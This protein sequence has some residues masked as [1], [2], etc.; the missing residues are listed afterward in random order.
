MA[1]ECIPLYTPGDVVTAQTTAAVTGKRVVA[2]T[3]AMA[4]GLPKVAHAT[5]AGAKFGIAVRDAASGG[6]VP[7][8]RGKGVILPVTAGAGIS[9]LAE[10]EVGTA[11]KVVTK[12]SGIAIGRALD[13]ASADGSDVFIELY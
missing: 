5:A 9:A 6:R 12:T 11:G 1:N 8:I 10:V 3:G 4:G 2:L 7:V 13:A